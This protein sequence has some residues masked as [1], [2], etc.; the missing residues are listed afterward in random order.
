MCVLHT[1]RLD[2]SMHHS[3]ICSQPVTTRANEQY[4]MDA[5]E[6]A[7]ITPSTSRLDYMQTG[8]GGEKQSDEPSNDQQHVI[9]D[10]FQLTILRGKLLDVI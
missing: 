7:V 4:M 5:D 2:T 1:N 9:H 6:G 10:Q 8:A 3:S